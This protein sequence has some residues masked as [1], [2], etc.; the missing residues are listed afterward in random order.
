MLSAGIPID[1]DF[2]GV[3][4]MKSGP[5]DER[6]AFA[7]LRA[8]IPAESNTATVNGLTVQ[9]TTDW[10]GD[11]YLLVERRSASSSSPVFRFSKINHPAMTIFTDA[12]PEYKIEVPLE[13]D[14]RYEWL[15]V[16]YRQEMCED[17]P[18]FAPAIAFL[19][20]LGGVQGYWG[21][22]RFETFAKL[23]HFQLDVTYP[24]RPSFFSFQLKLSPTPI[25]F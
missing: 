15:P 1:Y 8:A 4:C 13:I 10:M 24:Y 3:Y 11:E 12:P 25:E 22:E 6:D 17:E 20:V 18:S 14:H 9:R 19:S 5:L 16:S 2:P 7:H 21:R 23:F